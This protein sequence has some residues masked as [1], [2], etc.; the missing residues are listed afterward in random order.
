MEMAKGHEIAWAIPGDSRGA[1][2]RSDVDTNSQRVEQRFINNGIVWAYGG[3]ERWALTSTGLGYRVAGNSPLGALHLSGSTTSTSTTVFLDSFAFN[4]VVAFRR[5]N[6]GTT[7][8]ASSDEI[9]RHAYLGHDGT[10]YRNAARLKVMVDGAVSAN[11]VPGMFVWETTAAGETAPTERLRL[12][13]TGALVHRNNSTVIVDANSHIGLRAY[14][15]ATLPSASSASRLIYVS[16]GASSKRL[17]VSDGTNWRWPDG[18][19]VS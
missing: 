3:A 15:V 13:G 2:I 14:T 8:V 9:G 10:D 17:A 7:T 1:A 19:V 5:A 16:D 11:S 12:T 6:A 18:A 4:G